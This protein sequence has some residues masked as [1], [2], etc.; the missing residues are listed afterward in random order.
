[1]NRDVFV[2]LVT[3][4]V[5]GLGATLSFGEDSLDSMRISPAAA[6]EIRVD[7]NSGRS[8]EGLPLWS[9]DTIIVKFSATAPAEVRASVLL[10][11]QCTI[12][13]SCNGGDFHLVRIP[14]GDSPESVI[15]QLL[16]Y[17]GVEYAELNYYVYSTFLPNDEL[18]ALQWHL[19]N[20]GTGGIHME[21]AWNIQQCEPAIIVA[22][23]DTGVAYEDYAGFVQAPDL[24][25]VP[26]VPGYDFANE[27]EHANDD[28]GHGTHVAGTIAQS[29]NNSLGVA[30]VAFGC[31]IMPV[32]VLNSAGTG[33][34][35][36]V[37]R[38][39]YFAVE[40]GAAII[41]MSLGSRGDSKTLKDAV[42]AAYEKG[43]TCVCAAGNDGAFGSPISYPAGYDEYCIGVAATRYDETRSWFSTAGCYVD[44]AAPGGDLS[45]DQNKDKY[46]D[47][48]LQ[49]TLSGGIDSFGYAFYQGTSMATPHVSGLAAL[50]AA[51]GV[52]R[53]DKIA[54]AIELTARDRGPAGWDR[55]YGWGLIDASAAL[56]HRV[57]G[58]FGSDNVVDAG[59]LMAFFTQWLEKTHTSAIRLDSD[60]D[61]NRRVNFADFALLAANWDQ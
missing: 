11:S 5:I 14:N 52:T 57:Q 29:T 45:V 49:Q 4:V 26:F 28:Q 39:I 56:G 3:V 22:V 35:F 59:D 40:N 60:L 61:C 27:D 53:P 31:S 24:A 17:E 12:A 10:Q 32:K 50:L 7:P 15:S 13:E 23:V 41:N 9:P 6:D 43:V 25:G 33:T 54:H 48:V 47:G 8:L 1:M 37:A 42:A 30:G 38:G 46:P 51:R 36:N 16:F 20:R 58:D 21:R 18:Y 44:V 2:R 34:V 19:D 55:E